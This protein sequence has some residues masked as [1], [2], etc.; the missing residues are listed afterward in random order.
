M[1]G[2]WICVQGDLVLNM[3]E[4]VVEFVLKL[5]LNAKKLSEVEIDPSDTYVAVIIITTV[6]HTFTL[7]SPSLDDAPITKHMSRK[8][9]CFVLPLQNCAQSTR[10]EVWTRHI[11]PRV[12]QLTASYIATS[13]LLVVVKS[14][15]QI[16][17]WRSLFVAWRMCCLSV[18]PDG[19][20]VCIITLIYLLYYIHMQR[21]RLCRKGEDR[22][23]GSGKLNRA[24]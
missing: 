6:L 13:P 17:N 14:I 8:C 18:S 20:Y 11:L 19:Y 22:K 23:L 21:Y 3:S 7:C 4:L 12:R 9:N 15:L 24:A 5:A 1:H 10:R 16:C 2:L